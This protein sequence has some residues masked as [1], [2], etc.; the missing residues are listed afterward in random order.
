MDL[1]SKKI[2]DDAEAL[3]EK[4]QRSIK[5]LGTEFDE[6]AARL[7]LVEEETR[8]EYKRLVCKVRKSLP[9]VWT[10]PADELPRAGLTATPEFLDLLDLSCL[11]GELAELVDIYPNEKER[12]KKMAGE[13]WVCSNKIGLLHQH[14]EWYLKGHDY[15]PTFKELYESV[16][17]VYGYEEGRADNGKKN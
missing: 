12:L 1:R 2:L 7:N 17:K 10:C 8:A 5:T 15:P 9:E 4:K 6:V 13:I 11:I 3:L 16:R 14:L